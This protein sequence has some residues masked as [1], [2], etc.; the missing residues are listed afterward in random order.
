MV[1][2]LILGLF[3]LRSRKQTTHLDLHI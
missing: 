3:G 1:G 2:L